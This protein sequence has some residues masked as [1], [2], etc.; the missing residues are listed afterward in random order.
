MREEQFT[1]GEKRQL[2]QL[3]GTAYERELGAALREL[4]ATFAE[5]ERGSITAFDMSEAI[6]EFSKGIAR[7][8]WKRYSP[9]LDPFNVARAIGEGYLT[10]AEVPPA[11]REKLSG[12][13][14]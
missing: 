7:E 14:P 8:L 13:G 6:H 12:Q 11:L 9:R 5:W 1:K 3:A 10:E 4:Q 2:R